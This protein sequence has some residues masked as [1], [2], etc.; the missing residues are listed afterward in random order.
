[1]ALPPKLRRDPTGLAEVEGRNAV[2][3]A[4]FQSS[5]GSDITTSKTMKIAGGKGLKKPLEVHP[6]H[7]RSSP[8]SRRAK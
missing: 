1:M 6:H 5:T 8:K 4:A 3:A 7:Q 2:F